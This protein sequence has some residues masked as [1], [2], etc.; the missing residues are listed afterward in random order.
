[1]SVTHLYCKSGLLLIEVTHNSVMQEYYYWGC[2]KK[3]KKESKHTSK[4]SNGFNKSNITHNAELVLM[5]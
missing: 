3:F 1:M 4:C 2:R 5:C